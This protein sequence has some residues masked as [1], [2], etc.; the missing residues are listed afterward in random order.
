MTQFKLELTKKEFEFLHNWLA[1]DY[2]L[3]AEK[4]VNDSLNPRS[5]IVLRNLIKI[6][7]KFRKE[8]KN[9]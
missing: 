5:P 6:L 1:E 9:G 2:H 4:E 3:E 8:V 7:K